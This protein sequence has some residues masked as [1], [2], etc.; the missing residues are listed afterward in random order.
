MAIDGSF[1]S[2]PSFQMPP[3][4]LDRAR[5]QQPLPE[6]PQN[7][8]RGSLVMIDTFQDSYR[9]AAH[10]NVGAYAARQH[11]FR[12]QIYAENIGGD[13][14]G[15][16]QH[17]ER[18]NYLS[19]QPRTPAQ[20]QQA[21][22][23]I[24]RHWPQENLR[25]V[26][27]D[28]DKIRGRGLRDSAVNISYGIHP[29]IVAEDLY[30]QVRTAPQTPPTGPFANP[31][32]YQFA[33]NVYRAYGIDQAKFNSTDPQVSGPERL[34][35]QQALLNAAQQGANSAEVREAQ[36]DYG[37]A[38]RQLEANNNSVVASAGNQEQL[39]QDLARDANGLRV[40]ANP[41]SNRNLYVTPDVTNVGA[42]RF[43]NNGQERIAPYS[44]RDP[45]IDLFASG[46]VGNGAN[47]NRMNVW[48]TSYAAPRVAGAMA[49]LHGNH[50]GM[51]SGAVQNL[52]RNRL[53]HDMGQERVLDFRLAEEYMR[54][55]TF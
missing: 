18:Q 46:S 32:Q 1:P 40:Q 14:S 53:S 48:G 31:Q 20:T 17:A 6:V 49:S 47:Q 44:T 28:L 34:R 30:R 33:Q 29:Q 8:E 24:A 35:L 10:G 50:P 7:P 52:M 25:E 38:V 42:T 13:V 26:T 15:P 43:L 5:A 27:A 23:D 9:G 41:N 55:G 37:R 16:S 19:G 22:N 45:G 2:F 3:L 21:I 11:G 4:P 39:L 54:Q 12:G 51:P 36:R